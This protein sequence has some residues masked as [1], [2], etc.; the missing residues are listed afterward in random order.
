MRGRV[1]SALTA[2]PVAFAL[3]LTGCAARDD[4]GSEV[5]SVTGTQAATSA[6]PSVDPQEKGIKYA[7]CMREHGIDMADPEPGKGVMLKIGPG[8]PREK[9]EQAQQACKEW[10]PI[11]RD[12]GGGDPKRA[13][14][15]REVAQCMR[16]NGVEKYP[17]P[18]GGMM[19]ITRDV[20]DD[21]DFKTAQEKCQKEMA[22]AGMGGLG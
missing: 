13:E 10:A 19:R 4:G 21:P 20:G 6:S 14:A 7:Q 22:E 11:G 8:T 16:D 3:L 1:R 5:A 12:Q 17:D 9:V 2:A 15:L 18:E